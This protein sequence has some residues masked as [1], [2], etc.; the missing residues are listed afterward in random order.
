MLDFASGPS[1]VEALGEHAHPVSNLVWADRHGSIGYKTVGRLPI[2]RGGCPDLPKPGW[3]GEHE[4]E[5]WV[6]YE[7]MPELTDPDAGFVV[8][9]NNRIAPEDYPHHITSDYL[10]GYRARRIEQLITAAAR[11]RP[12]ELRGD[13]DGHALASRAWRPRTGWPGCGRATSASWRRSSGCAP[14][15]GG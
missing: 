1:L 13:A 9:A 7:E 6:P 8:T 4:W 15:T 12:G 2:R 10:D 3:T 14:G 5:G 11:A